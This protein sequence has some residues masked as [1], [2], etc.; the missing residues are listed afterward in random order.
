MYVC[1]ILLPIIICILLNITCDISEWVTLYSA[2]LIVVLLD[3]YV[4]FIFV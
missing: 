4:S 1:Y 2:V 3:Y